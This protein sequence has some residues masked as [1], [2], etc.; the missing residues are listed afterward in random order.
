MMDLSIALVNWNNRD[1]LEQC[2]ESIEAAQLPLAYEIVVSDNGSTDGS[3]RMLAE[4]YP[5]VVVIENGENVGVAR[6]N[7]QCI[8]HSTGRYIYILNN[9]TVVNRGSIMRMVEFLDEHPEAGAAGGDLLNP[10]GSFQAGFCRFPSLWEEFLIVTHVGKRL[11]PHFPSHDGP[12]PEIREVDWISSASIVVRREAIEQI[13]L[14][15]EA[16]FVYSDETDWQYRLWQAGWKVYYLPEVTTIHYG[17]GSFQLGGKRFTLVYRGRMLFA[18][19]H[20]GFLYSII[21]RAMF[22]AAALGR[23]V[24]WAI[25]C[26]LPRWR[27]VAKRQLA[28]NLETLG[29][30]FNLK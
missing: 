9:D 21:Q 10:D 5:D 22:A 16:Y 27:S 26:A 29:L 13:G 14:V 15:D 1:Y 12:Y 3:L 20:Y 19:K 11:N 30:C 17:G 18:H 4:R 28:S 6:G 24:V 2:L 23:E 7:N 25:L 8:R